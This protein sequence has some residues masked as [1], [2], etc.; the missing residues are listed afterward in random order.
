[1]PANPD[2]SS[3]V[4]E[5]YSASWVHVAEEK[6]NKRAGSAALAA[7]SGVDVQPDYSWDFPA[8]VLLYQN[9]GYPSGEYCREYYSSTIAGAAAV[10]SV[11]VVVAAAAVAVE[12]LGPRFWWCL[13]HLPGCV[14]VVAAAVIVSRDVFGN[15][16]SPGNALLCGEEAEGGRGNGEGA[17]LKKGG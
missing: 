2:S 5:P 17:T 14:I 15:H 11:A 13:I 16:P 10:S 3:P 8:P 9:P 4:P 7:V 6:P 1:V 12:M